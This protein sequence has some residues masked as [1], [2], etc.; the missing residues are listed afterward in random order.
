M[1]LPIPTTTSPGKLVLIANT[2]TMT[3]LMGLR[4]V[5][6]VALPTEA[7]ALADATAFANVV[8]QLLI[9]QTSIVGYRITDPHGATIIE[10]A[11][12]PAI[13]GAALDTSGSFRSKTITVTGKGI[14]IVSGTRAGQTRVVIFSYGAVA[15]AAGQKSIVLSSISTFVPFVTYL[16]DN[17]RV[18]A[19]FYGQKALVRG[20]API[21]FNAHVQRKYGT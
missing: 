16:R 7:E 18:W 5:H 21:Q 19:D 20:I 6:D 11:F 17:P 9:N 12:T 15:F 8:K 3:H 2:E 13:M 4:Y 10:G 14:P 1:G